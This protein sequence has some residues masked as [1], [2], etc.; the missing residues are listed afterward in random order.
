ML[1]LFLAPRPQTRGRADAHGPAAGSRM[2]RPI[3]R[4]RGW[5]DDASN[6]EDLR[7]G[8]SPEH[9]RLAKAVVVDA[10]LSQVVASGASRATAL[11]ARQRTVAT[12]VSYFW[13]FYQ[14]GSF[15][16]DEPV[17]V[18]VACLSL[19]GKTLE[20]PVHDH[21]KFVAL[22]NAVAAETYSDAASDAALFACA[23]DA[24]LPCEL[25]V[26]D[27]LKFDLTPYDPHAALQEA[28]RGGRRSPAKE[29]GAAR[30][31]EGAETD[32][33]EATESATGRRMKRK[34]DDDDTTTYD[35]DD[36]D[37][38]TLFRV[39]WGVLNDSLV[40]P[41]CVSV[42]ERAA[43]VAAVA[44]ACE[45]LDVEPP[46]T[47]FPDG[48]NAS[49]AAAAADVPAG[50]VALAAREMVR[51]RAAFAE[52]ADSKGRGA[53]AEAPKG[54]PA[55]WRARPLMLAARRAQAAQIIEE[56]RRAGRHSLSGRLG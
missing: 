19:A 25:R 35:D 1:V 55:G 30:R 21:T 24:L 2:E 42:S 38:E 13:R 8:F 37:D 4:P 44:V 6:P 10:L 20:N 43:A 18:A 32:A 14:R 23:P 7:L 53:P 15:A 5:T 16:T 34:R 26:L 56:A 39:A 11:H 51:H 36:D 12:A 3:S 49:L 28:L 27:A 17:L 52:T 33:T 47:A 48:E 50:H 45:L 54:A 31:R 29:E 22:A 9:V 46:E 41:T 40:T